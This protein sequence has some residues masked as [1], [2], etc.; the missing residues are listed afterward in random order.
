[1]QGDFKQRKVA[2]PKAAETPQSSLV[3]SAKID[4]A[5]PTADDI[6]DT[7]VLDDN[8][9]E[10]SKTPTSNSEGNLFTRPFIRLSAWWKTLNRNV[11]F[12]VIGAGIILFCVI[13]LAI[14]FFASPGSNPSFTLHKGKKTPAIN[15]VASPLTGVQVAPDLAKRPVTGI[16][17]ENSTDARPQSG[18]QDAGV[19][20]EA[21]AEAGI[22]RFLALFQDAR[23]QYIG[24]VRSL[25][26]YFIDYAA[27]YQASIVHVGGSPDALSE[28]ENGNYRNLDQFFNGDY[29]TRISARAAPHNVYTGFDLLDKLNQ[30]KGYTSSTFTSWPRKK[31]SRPKTPTTT[32]IDLAI[33]SEA[34]HVHYDYDAGSNSY[35]RSEGGAPHV[36]L[37]SA[38]DAAGVQ[39]KPK[40]VIALVV[41]LGQGALD[42]SGAYY[43]NYQTYGS[44]IAYV[45]Q[46]G[47]VTQGTWTKDGTTGPLQFT[48][49][50]GHALN[51]NAGQT[52]V[53]LVSDTSQVSYK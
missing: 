51:L 31:D 3:K 11:R 5:P 39:L 10:P 12:G 30:S 9:A 6:D 46:D 27:P 20:Y 28:V 53:T 2:A 50:N 35:L 48:D 15:T 49:E 23:P 7:I 38:S 43:S 44:G 8:N 45:F 33:S 42:A 16:M 1:M 21:V 4:P 14:Y 41:P 36:D 32:S 25:R 19:V 24:P 18:L 52:W 13:A 17:I 22:T 47:G 34:Y 40:V 26:P 29:F 37:V